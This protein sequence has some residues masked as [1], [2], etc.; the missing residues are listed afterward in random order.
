[1][2][3]FAND[4]SAYF[5]DTNFSEFLESGYFADTNFHELLVPRSVVGTYSLASVRPSVGLFIRSF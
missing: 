4:A 1:M 2:L 5:V 3:I